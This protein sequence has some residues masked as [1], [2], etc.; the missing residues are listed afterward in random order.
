MF[1]S[2][3]LIHIAPTDIRK[4]LKEIHRC[5]SCFIWGFEYYADSYT[6]VNYREHDQLLWKADF[7]AL[8]LD[9]FRDLKLVKEEHIKYCNEDNVNTMFLL[10]KGKD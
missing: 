3:V 2:G 10:K 5:S 6:E 1:T 7:T 8:Y 9:E 4:V